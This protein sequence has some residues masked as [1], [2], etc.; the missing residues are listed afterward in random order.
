MRN[1]YKYSRKTRGNHPEDLHIGGKI[2]LKRILRASGYGVDL[3]CSR[4]G[5][6]ADSCKYA[7]VQLG[8]V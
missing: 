1:A 3:T 8:Y 5:A 4:Y 2:I 6:V 7:V